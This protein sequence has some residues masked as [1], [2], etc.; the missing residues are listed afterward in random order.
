MEEKKAVIGIGDYVLAGYSHY[1]LQSDESGRAIDQLKSELE[2]R[3]VNVWDCASGSGGDP[4]EALANLRENEPAGS[5]LVVRNAGWFMRDAAGNV[6]YQLIQMIQNW[7]VEFR[8]SA[9]RKLL[10]CVGAEGPDVIPKEVARE[11]VYLALPLP[12][13]EEIAEK[14]ERMAAALRKDK[15]WVEPP[16]TARVV[17]A[18]KGMT[19]AE[20]DNSLAFSAVKKRTFDSL[21]IKVQRASFLEKVAG[22]KY[23]EYQDDFSQLQGY[24]V[25]K[26]FWKR[27]APPNHPDA[28][29]VLLLGPPG[30]G[31]SMAAKCLAREFGMFMLTCEMAE[32]T[33]SLVGETEAKV[34]AFIDAAVAMAP[35]MVF[36]DKFLSMLNSLNCWD[37]LR[38]CWA[39]A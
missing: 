26:D 34:K 18:C 1:W 19:L 35:C 13:A 6:N 17:D 38:G 27:V 8:S 7:A 29:G 20:I 30:T 14:V 37:T 11:F 15:L 39:T 36:I 2:G 9:K 21:L 31:K 28:K 25:L 4:S 23:V 12:G 24:S 5:V 32:M 10:V 33:G 16:D 3:R 22:V